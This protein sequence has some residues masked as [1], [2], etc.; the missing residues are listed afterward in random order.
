MLSAPDLSP[1]VPKDLGFV[2][3]YGGFAPPRPPIIPKFRTHSFLFWFVERCVAKHALDVF[4]GN[5]GTLPK[6]GFGAYAHSALHLSSLLHFS[7][8]GAPFLLCWDW[9]CLGL[10]IV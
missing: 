1:F 4:A 9:I 10:V 7:W 5:F 3:D 6:G 2:D 8:G